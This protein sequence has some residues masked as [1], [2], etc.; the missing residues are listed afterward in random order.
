MEKNNH[1]DLGVKVS[2][3]MDISLKIIDSGQVMR[4]GVGFGIRVNGDFP[5]IIN[6]VKNIIQVSNP[7]FY[8]TASKLLEAYN[9]S[10]IEFAL[11]TN[12]NPIQ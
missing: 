10:N 2:K 6:P 4:L 5:I 8:E 12:Y 3:L 1:D 9:L 7:N 11:R